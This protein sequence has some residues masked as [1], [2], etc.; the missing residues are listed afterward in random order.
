L[1]EVAKKNRDFGSSASALEIGHRKTVVF[2]LWQKPR[3]ADELM[4]Q[5]LR[6]V[7]N[8]LGHNQYLEAQ[9]G[10]IMRTRKRIAVPD[11]TRIML[12]MTRSMDGPLGDGDAIVELY[13]F[14]RFAFMNNQ[15]PLSG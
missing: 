13:G 4:R 3:L 5:N 15:Q 11:K 2:W 7:L 1:K 8:R 10:L 12:K 9:D 6:L 14:S